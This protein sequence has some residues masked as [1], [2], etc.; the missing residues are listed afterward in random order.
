MGKARVDISFCP[1]QLEFDNG[2]TYDEE[3]LLSAVREFAD[4]HFPD[5]AEF[6]TLQVGHR[7]GDAWATVNGDADEG[8]RFLSE[9]FLEHGAD[10]ELFVSE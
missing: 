7:Q 10:E 2:D 5:G 3:K 8:E 9:F 4:K 1:T 6:I